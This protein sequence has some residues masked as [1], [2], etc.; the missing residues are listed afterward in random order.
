MASKSFFAIFLFFLFLGFADCQDSPP[1]FPCLNPF[2]PGCFDRRQK[3]AKTADGEDGWFICGAE[4]HRHECK[5]WES[6]AQKGLVVKCSQPPEAPTGC[7]GDCLKNGCDWGER[8]V[9]FSGHK[10]PRHC[11]Y[12]CEATCRKS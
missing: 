4:L 2:M 5:K 1:D 10:C 12:V 8:C 6:C 7:K 3:V 9:I 11:P